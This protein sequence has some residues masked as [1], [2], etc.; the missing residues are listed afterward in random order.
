LLLLAGQV[1]GRSGKKNGKDFNYEEE[2]IDHRVIYDSG[3]E[4]ARG[5]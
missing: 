3:G 2:P 4:K 5:W 1:Y